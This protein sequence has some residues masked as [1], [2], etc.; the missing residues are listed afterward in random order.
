MT[1]VEETKEEEEVPLAYNPDS[2]ITHINNIKIEDHDSFLDCLLVN[3][4]EDF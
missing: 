4:T 2:L 1:T 3:D